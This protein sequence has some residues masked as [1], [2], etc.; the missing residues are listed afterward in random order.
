[1][2]YNANAINTLEVS[3]SFRLSFDEVVQTFAT[4]LLHTLEAELQVDRQWFAI[5][6]VVL[7]NIKPP[8][9]RTLVVRRASSYKLA[10]V[11]DYEG[12]WIGVPSIGLVGLNRH[13][14]A[15]TPELK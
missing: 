2:T 15:C 13:E 3:S 12:E 11:F 9:N 1:M 14:I 6:V 4:A 5:G 10:I 8:E 7:K